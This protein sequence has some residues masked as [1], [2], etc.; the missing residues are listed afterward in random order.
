MVVCVHIYSLALFIERAWGHLGGSTV[1]HLA[2]VMI[3][4]FVGSSPTHVG[5]YADSVEP[6]WFSLSPYLCPSP[7][8]DSFVLLSQ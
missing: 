7:T 1:K 3:S 5:L 6:A 4:L 8:R 2:Q